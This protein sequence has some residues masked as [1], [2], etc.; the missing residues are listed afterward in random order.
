MSPRSRGRRRQARKSGGRPGNPHLSAVPAT[1]ETGEY[2]EEAACWFEEP[3]PGNRR[4]WAV[5]PAHGTYQGRDLELLDP[6][7]ED[8]R[9][10]L[11]EAR[12]PAFAGALR[13]GEDVIVDGEAVN[14]RL[15]VAMHQVA[16]NQLLAEDPP[17]TWQAVQRLAGL[18]YDWHTIMHMIASLASEDVYRA[19]WEHWQHDPAA[20]ARRLSELP[21]GWPPPEP[22]R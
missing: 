7:D 10:L 13:G 21:G 14:P 11:I 1:D 15:H 5:P 8:E 12:H 18:G 22:A 16:A 9:T 6:S 17:E 3:E 2:G 19:L 20:Y 4:S